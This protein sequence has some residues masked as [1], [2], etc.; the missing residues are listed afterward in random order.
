MDALDVAAPDPALQDALAGAAADVGVEQRGRD[1]AQ[2]IDLGEARKR[3]PDRLERGDV[4]V[5]EAARAQRGPADRVDLAVGERQRLDQIVGDALGAQLLD[6]LVVVRAVRGLDPA[7]D[8]LGGPEDDRDRALPI[9][10]ASRACRSAASL[11]A[12][13]SPRR[14][15]KRRP[16]TSGC[17]V[18]TNTATRCSGR[19][20]ARSRSHSSASTSC[21]WR[22][23][24]APRISQSTTG[25]TLVGCRCAPIESRPLCPR[26]MPCLAYQTS[27]RR[28]QPRDARCLR[29]TSPRWLGTG[30]RAPATEKPARARGADRAR[31]ARPRG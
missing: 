2:R 18:V 31:L 15:R 23:V 9:G 5:A 11:I 10:V 3:Q 22:A 19:P 6:D 20:Q 29:L 1:P 12:T 8:R 28:H 14:Q 13:P 27:T 25:C 17:S 30:P 4:G 21:G 7:A 26:R 16:M 24:G